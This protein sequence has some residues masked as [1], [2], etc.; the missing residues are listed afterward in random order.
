[1]R[2]SWIPEST[3]FFFYSLTRSTE[4]HNSPRHCLMIM[5]PSQNPRNRSSICNGLPVEI[6]QKCD[7]RSGKRT[8]G[9]VQEILTNSAFHPHGIKVRLTDGRV[10][11]VVTICSPDTMRQDRKR[12]C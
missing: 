12:Q 8:P 6:I 2:R 9:T 11:R 10:G 5:T 7:Q 1:M 4:P 3:G